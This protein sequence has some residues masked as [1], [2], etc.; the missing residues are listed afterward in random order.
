M[1]PGLRPCSPC[2]TCYLCLGP[3]FLKGS[4]RTASQAR[5]GGPSPEPREVGVD[6]EVGSVQLDALAVYFDN[7][8]RG[9]HILQGW[10][11]GGGSRVR[12]GS[13]CCRC[14]ARFQALCCCPSS[15]SPEAPQ[16]ELCACGEGHL[17]VSL[18][19]LTEFSLYSGYSSTSRSCFCSANPNSSRL[20]KTS[21]SSIWS[22]S[23]R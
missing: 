2:K 1:R 11:W 10:G 5:F 21:V 17:L 3:S 7:R 19:P 6:A 16:A 22:R 9:W 15:L 8:S 23:E 20:E 18:H 12:P 14:E 4:P 13:C